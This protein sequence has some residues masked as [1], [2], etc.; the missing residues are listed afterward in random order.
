MF[1]KRNCFK[2]LKT[3][4]VILLTVVGIVLLIS[5]RES[6]YSPLT[7]ISSSHY[8]ENVVNNVIRSSTVIETEEPGEAAFYGTTV[9][10]PVSGKPNYKVHTFYYPWYG[11]PQFDDNY[12]HWNHEYLPNW[13][14]NDRHTYPEGRHQPPDDIGANFYPLLGCYSSRDL[15]VVNQHMKWIRDA[16]IGVLVISWYPPDEA[17]QEGKPFDKLFPLF[18]DTAVKYHLKVAFHIEP[19][20]NRNPKNLRE[21]IEYIID[22]YGDH[23]SLYRYARNTVV[24]PLPVFYIYDSYLNTAKSWSAL[25]KRNGNFSIRGT[26]YDGIFLGLLVELRHKYIISSGWFVHFE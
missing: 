13:D 1:P 12:L 18:L 16:G 8:R 23:P 21:N 11:N 14:K 3:A 4:S 22:K 2:F 26:R 5:V 9:Q 19:Y 17:D 10:Q 24:E 20:K 25:L 15:S 7:W 6:R